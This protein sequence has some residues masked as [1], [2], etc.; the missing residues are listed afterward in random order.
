MPPTV[1]ALSA[2]LKGAYGDDR[3]VYY[4]SEN[5]SDLDWHGFS[6]NANWGI[7][8]PYVVCPEHNQ[9]AWEAYEAE[10]KKEEEAPSIPEI[11]GDIPTI[12]E[13]DIQG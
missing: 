2:G 1:S 8:A 7:S 3:Y 4:V 5:G 9:A 6:G 10:Q 11:D 12:P 13:L